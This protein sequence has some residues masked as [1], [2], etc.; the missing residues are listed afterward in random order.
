M[1]WIGS[2]SLSFFWSIRAWVLI[3]GNQSLH[4]MGLFCF[5]F[6]TP[7]GLFFL[8][9]IKASSSDPT[10]TL[11]FYEGPSIKVISV[12]KNMNL[13]L[14]FFGRMHKDP[15]VSLVNLGMWKCTGLKNMKPLIHPKFFLH[16][17]ISITCGW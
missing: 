5:F 1:Y 8:R 10:S 12:T 4:I 11:G 13:V 7:M 14:S 15:K 6:L 16:I 3:Q 2:K 17:Y 9:P